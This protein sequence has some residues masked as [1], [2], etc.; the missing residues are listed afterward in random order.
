MINTWLLPTP[1]GDNAVMHVIIHIPC[2][3][4]GMY[5]VSSRVWFIGT[6]GKSIQSVPTYSS[7]ELTL[8]PVLRKGLFS[9]PHHFF[10]LF[11]FLIFAFLT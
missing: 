6:E 8:T 7:S 4:N 1:P 10:E 3:L 5:S 11:T 9:N 2:G